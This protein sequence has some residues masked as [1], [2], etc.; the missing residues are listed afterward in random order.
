M[1]DQYL[2]RQGLGTIT[3]VFLSADQTSDEIG[4]AIKRIEAEIEDTGQPRLDSV[5]ATNLISHGVDLERI[6]NMMC[7]CGMPSH[8][9]EYVQSSSRCE[10]SHPGLVFACFKSADPRE[11]SQYQTFSAFH[12]HLDRLIEPSC[13]QSIRK[14]RS[15]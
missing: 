15:T 12:R 11:A 6:I 3:S 8:Y 14:L 2:E 4:G 10:R 9:N 5:I 7:V 13:S 1:I